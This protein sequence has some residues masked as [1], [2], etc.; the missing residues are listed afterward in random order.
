MSPLARRSG[1]NDLATSQLSCH[2]V[3]PRPPI[4]VIEA[5]ARGHRVDI[6]FGMRRIGIHKCIR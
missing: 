6:A 1:N 2:C 5:K 3:Q 4:V